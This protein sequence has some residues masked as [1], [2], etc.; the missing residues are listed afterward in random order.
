MV[1]AIDTVGNI[2]YDL[3][4]TQIIDIFKEVGH[5][6]S[7]RLMFDR[8]TGKPK[9][10]GFCT[11]EDH[12]TASSAVRNLNNYDINGRTLRVDFADNEKDEPKR[13]EVV[14]LI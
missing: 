8:E 10:Y 12:E 3:S 11:F 7:F 9:G 6:V 14:N 13:D 2:P 1:I 5:V 4:E